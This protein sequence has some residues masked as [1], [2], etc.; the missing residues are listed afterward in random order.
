MKPLK[1]MLMVI[2][3]VIHS[4]F[5]CILATPHSLWDQAWVVAVKAQNPNPSATREYPFKISFCP[6]NY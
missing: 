5:P 2:I 6:H 3:S 1:I 4:Y